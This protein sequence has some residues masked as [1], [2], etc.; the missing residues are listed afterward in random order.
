MKF[1]LGVALAAAALGQTFE[2]ASVKPAAAGQTGGVVRPMPGNQ[3]YL[4]RNAPLSMIMSVAYQVTNRQI[5]GGP[6]WMGTD[7][8]DI[9]AKADKAYPVEQLRAM[10]QRLLEERFQMKLRREPREMPVYELVVD[11]GGPKMT[12]H[13]SNDINRGPLRAGPNG[14]GF[15]G[16]N[17]PMNLLALNLSRIL[18]RNVI[19]KTGLDGY[20]DFTVDFARN[21]SDT[22]GP[23]VFTALREQLGLRLVPAKGPVE[24]IV[25]EAAERPSAN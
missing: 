7:P 21:P 20:W 3:E 1:A 6:S 10:L 12:K 5:T 18:D 2:V 8:W 16:T 24:H 17:A 19:D 25:I 14:R 22:E 9:N 13:D 11:K 23:T 15:A 4:V